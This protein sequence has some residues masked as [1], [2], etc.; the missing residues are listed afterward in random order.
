M[1]KVKIG[2]YNPKYI[3]LALKLGNSQLLSFILKF[4]TF[5]KKF[6]VKVLKFSEIL[7]NKN[8]KSKKL[9]KGCKINVKAA[10]NQNRAASIFKH[11]Q[12]N[13]CFSLV[14]QQMPLVLSNAKVAR[15]RNRNKLIS[16]GFDVNFTFFFV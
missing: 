4:R 9:Q 3:C 11:K 15:S 16:Y 13:L 8:K 7:Q 12:S 10:A 6:I 5:H 1:M 14:S 2:C